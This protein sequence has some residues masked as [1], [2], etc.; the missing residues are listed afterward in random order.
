MLLVSGL[1][2]S[3]LGLPVL[4]ARL[5]HAVAVK[6]AVLMPKT[7]V[8]EYHCSAGWEH[9]IWAAGHRI[10]VQAIAIPKRVNKA[11]HSHLRLCIFVP[12]KGHSTTAL[13]PRQ[14][15]HRGAF[16]TSD[17]SVADRRRF[18]NSFRKYF[19]LSGQPKE[20]GRRSQPE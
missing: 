12:D 18:R 9:E 4:L 15:V 19:A 1:V 3:Q 8:N 20:A 16:A 13:F 6:T 7:A 10:D 2:A 17:C 14:I 11:T 5:G